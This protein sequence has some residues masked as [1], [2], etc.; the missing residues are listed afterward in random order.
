MALSSQ[1][2][3]VVVGSL[4]MRN[5]KNSPYYAPNFTLDDLVRAMENRLQTDQFLRTYAKETRVMWCSSIDKDSHSVRFIIHTG[6]KNIAGISFL[7]FKTMESRDIDK[8][9]NEGSH[10]SAHVIIQRNPILQGHH[11]IL[12]EKVPGIYLFSVKDHFTWICNHPNYE[13]EGVD[14]D[15]TVKRFHSIFE[16]DGHQSRTVRDALKTGSLQDIQFISHEETYPDGLDEESVIREIVHKAQWDIKRKVTEDEAR[17][18]FGRV[19]NFLK[20]EKADRDHTKMFI[21]I[22]ADNGQIKTSEIEYDGDEILEQA[23]VQNEMISDF[24][25]PL[26]Q[27]YKD[28]RQDVIG[29]MQAIAKKFGE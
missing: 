13:K 5:R 12:I 21:R 1:Y 28:I 3:W 15:G 10:Y 25:Q 16:I 19:K 29:K 8:E 24:E 26:T 17:I 14:N 22:K 27:R 6:D 2:R 20:K 11:L 23:F 4:L 9:D 7:N 18:V